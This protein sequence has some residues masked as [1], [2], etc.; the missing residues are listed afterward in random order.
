MLLLLLL[1]IYLFIFFLKILVKHH[2]Q[3]SHR[4]LQMLPLPPTSDI[5][6]MRPVHSS[7]S[8][9]HVYVGISNPGTSIFLFVI[10]IQWCAVLATRHKINLNI[11]TIIIIMTEEHCLITRCPYIHSYGSRERNIQRRCPVTQRH[12]VHVVV[13]VVLLL[14]RNN[15]QKSSPSGRDFTCCLH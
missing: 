6:V 3:P 1:F 9:H 2:I 13:I 5:M 14:L 4:L 12:T 15:P 7:A 11:I 8:S 10:I